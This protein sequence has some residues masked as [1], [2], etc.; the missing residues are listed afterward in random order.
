MV[1]KDGVLRKAEYKY[2]GPFRITTV[3]MNGTIRIQRG[4]L[5]ER[6]NIRRVKPYHADDSD[7]DVDK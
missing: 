5:S 3:H 6:L 7:S 2:E 4:S 1:Q